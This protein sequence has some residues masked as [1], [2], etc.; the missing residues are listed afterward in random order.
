MADHDYPRLWDELNTTTL[1]G[2]TAASATQISRQSNPIHI[3][4]GNLSEIES[5]NVINAGLMRDGSPIPNTGQA[6]NVQLTDNTRTNWFTPAAGECWLLMSY[7]VSA[8]Q[9]PSSGY[10]FTIFYT[11]N[12][13]D[14]VSRVLEV[15]NSA[16][17]TQAL[18]PLAGI[19]TTSQSPQYIDENT[20]VSISVDNM[21]GTTTIDCSVYAMRVR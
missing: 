16:S 5:P 13:Q 2:S 1:G 15:G 21:Q 6:F 10:V 12:D 18:Q 7:S 11:T 19:S 17:I 9:A 8:N 3:E 4:A 20:T 14:G